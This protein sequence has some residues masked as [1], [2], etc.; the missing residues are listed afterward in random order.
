M[1]NKEYPEALNLLSGLIKE[2][3]RLDDKLLLVDINLLESKLHFSLR[4]LPKAKAS[5]TAARTAANAIYVPPAQQGNIDLQSG[6]LHAEEK[7]YKT[8]YSYFF[9]AFEA[10]NAL[11]DPRAVF[12]LKYMLCKIMVSQAD[13]VAGIRSSKAG[14]Q[15][16]GP[17]LDAMKAVADAHSKRSLKLFEIAL[18]DFQAQLEEDPIVHRHLSSLYDTLLEQNLCRLIEP[19]SRVE[20]A[21]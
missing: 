20:I 2:V 11:E 10:F 16:V 14:L 17:E 3:R 12:S 19:F 13:D 6:I 4:N 1:E 9:E 7:D 8:A 21:H 15:Y 18:R 5:L